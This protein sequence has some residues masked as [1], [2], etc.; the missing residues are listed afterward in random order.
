MHSATVAA[1]F[2]FLLILLRFWRG[3]PQLIV[4][5]L[6]TAFDR[7]ADL[8]A[9]IFPTYAYKHKVK[10]KAHEPPPDQL[11][12]WT[13]IVKLVMAL[14]ITFVFGGI[15]VYFLFSSHADKHAKEW[16]SGMI[17]TIVGYW[18]K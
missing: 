11:A 4:H 15:S 1:V 13:A 8:L 17:G 3:F 14:I 6:D 2:V 9:S 5:L 16:A 18:L 7:F 10:I 12:K